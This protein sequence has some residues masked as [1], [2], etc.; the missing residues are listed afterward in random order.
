MK[1]FRILSIDG[2]GVRGII[3]A[4]FLA[5]L[6]SLLDTD[7]VSG[8]FDLITGTSTG[9]VIAAVAATGQDIGGA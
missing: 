4:I 7:D 1:K 8:H 3:P 5:K 2:G 9:A 6:A